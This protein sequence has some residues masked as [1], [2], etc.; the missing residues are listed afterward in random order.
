MFELGQLLR[1][2]RLEKGIS[3][4]DL[5]EVTKIRK[6]YLEAIEEGNLKVLPG[7]FYIRAFIKSYAEAVGLDPNEVLRLYRNVIP[8]SEPE[9][10]AEPVRRKRTDSKNSEK[11]SKRLTG[12]MLWSFVLLIFGILYYFISTNAKSEGEENVSQSQTNEHLTDR[13]MSEVSAAPTPA[14]TASEQKPETKPS[15]T[16]IV[17]DKPD[18]K[19]TKSEGGKDFYQISKA[20]KVIVE[21]TVLKD[22]CWIGIDKQTK[23]GDS[24]QKETLFSESLLSGQYQKW[25]LDPS[26]NLTLGAANAVELKINGTVIPI[27]EKESVKRYQ[28][29]L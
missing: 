14:A 29:D 5:Q 4:E 25:E 27:G 17:P 28:F 2:A 7:T 18:V 9:Q 12:I 15:Q 11:W 20:S 23:S 19:L 24:V 21:V 8:V 6:R 1:K 10:T 3:L 13:K 22:K 16:P 26:V